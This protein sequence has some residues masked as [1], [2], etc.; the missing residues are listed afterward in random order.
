M[1]LSQKYHKS[2]DLKWSLRFSTHHPE[3]DNFYG[4]VT[5][6]QKHFIVLREHD[7][8][9]FNGV[10]IVPKKVI[11]G[12]RDGKVDRCTNEILRHSGA[13][14]NA[15]SPRW[16]DTCTTLTDILQ[17]LQKRDI[18]PAV[19][20]MY[21][22]DGKTET[23]FFIGIITRIEK[24]AFW[25]YDYSASGE[26]QKEWEIK[27]DEIFKIEFDDQYSRHFNAY[28]R[29]IPLKNNKRSGAVSVS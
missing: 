7:E 10:L 26:W 20:I 22:L 5:H 28:M 11:K 25:I 12:C 21:E 24:D 19:E 16:L 2:R 3:G 13:I 17:K 8:F 14:K 27:F 1:S 18:W 15:K 6:I 29:T 23:E 4:V 9:E